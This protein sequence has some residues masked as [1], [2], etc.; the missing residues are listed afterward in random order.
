MGRLYVNGELELEGAIAAGS[1]ITPGSGDV[2][3]GNRL[4]WAPQDYQG[5]LDELRISNVVRTKGEIQES[6]KGL[7][8]TS[9]TPNGNITITWAS[10]KLG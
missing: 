3:I 1:K 10:I 5:S 2:H 9:V 7:S 4:E 8:V 6:M